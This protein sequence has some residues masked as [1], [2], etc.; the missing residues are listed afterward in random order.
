[1]GAMA[2][3]M[4]KESMGRVVTP[5]GEELVGWSEMGRRMSCGGIELFELA[6]ETESAQ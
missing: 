5:F 2:G 4:A 6:L 3:W 1:M